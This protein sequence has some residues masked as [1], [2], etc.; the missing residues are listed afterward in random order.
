MFVALRGR[1]AGQGN[2]V[3]LGPV[4]H[5]AVPVGLGPVLEHTVQPALGEAPLDVLT[6]CPGA[7]SR[8]WATLGADQPSPV[9]SRMRGPVDNPGGT[10]SR[11]DHMLQLVCVPP[12][13]AG[14]RISP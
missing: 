10:L 7:T 12:A 13:S 8:A 6:P 11:P 5:L 9:F 3:A 4:I 14:P 2:Q 1:T